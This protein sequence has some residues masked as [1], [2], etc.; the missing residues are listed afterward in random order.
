M[1]PFKPI[2][3][4][5]VANFFQYVLRHTVLISFQNVFCLQLERQPIPL[6]CHPG[7]QLFVQDRSKLWWFDRYMGLPRIVKLL[8]NVERPYIYIAVIIDQKDEQFVIW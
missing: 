7:Y 8:S 5:E 2:A 1:F 3:I 6:I 4:T